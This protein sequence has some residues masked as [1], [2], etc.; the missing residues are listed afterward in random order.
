MYE[1][2]TT[3]RAEERDKVCGESVG[4]RDWK[5]FVKSVRCGDELGEFGGGKEER[6]SWVKTR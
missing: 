6:T 4:K 3:R 1:M 5:V 2:R